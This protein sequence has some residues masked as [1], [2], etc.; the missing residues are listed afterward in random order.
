MGIHHSTITDKKMR[1]KKKTTVRWSVLIVAAMLAFVSVAQSFNQPSALA[2]QYDDKI[3]DLQGKIDSY[4][5]QAVDLAAQA[6]TLNNK[7]AELQNQQ[8]QIQAQ[9]DLT[10]AQIDDLNDKIAE[11]EVKLK[12]QG[13][14]LSKTLADIYYSQQT[15]TLDILLNSDSVSDYVDA[16]TRQDSMRA[17]LTESIDAI[18][19]IKSQLSKQK[20]DAER[21]L[22]QQQIQK[23]SLVASRQ[24]Q[25]KLLADTQ[26]K[27][28]TYQNMIK[29][30]QA[31]IAKL[32]AQQIADNLAAQAKYGGAAVPGDPNHGGYPN[33]LN[34]ARQDSLIDPWGMYNRECVS[35]AA[36]KV[37]QTFGYM[38]HWGGYKPGIDTPILDAAGVY[39]PNG[40][41]VSGHAKYWIEQARHN[42]VPYGTTPK[43]HSVAVRIT[44]TYGHVAWVESVNGSQ[45]HIS[46]YNAGAADGK[47]SEWVGDYHAFQYYIYFGEW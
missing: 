39:K 26:G 31:E 24:E 19:K 44:G 12:E 22:T 2:D 27:E 18:N 8:A 45:I 47:Y 30:S 37:Q 23:D 3:A 36:W 16:T 20:S 9:I 25:E 13:S 1:I 35:Y 21:L 33:Y 6:D 11:N 42:G 34:N 28:A 40:G 5:A 32:Q 43:P 7:I 29:E 15:S 10:N 14:T 41:M 38:P 17:Q 4:T 46:Q